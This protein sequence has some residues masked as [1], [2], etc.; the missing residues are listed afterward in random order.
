MVGSDGI[1]RT[2][3]VLRS[4]PG[5]DDSALQAALQWKFRP[6]R[7]HGSPVSA[8]AVLVFAFRQPIASKPG[9]R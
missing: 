9:P 2:A 3:T 1:V 5:F 4:A 6:A 7:L 8:S